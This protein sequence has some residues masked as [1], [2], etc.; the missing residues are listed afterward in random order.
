[1][2]KKESKFKKFK[3][4]TKI[5]L[6]TNWLVLIAVA[7]LAPIYA[8][9]VD[10]VWWDL[11]DASIAWWIFALSAWITSLISWKIT[12]NLKKKT[13]V[14]VFWYFLMWIWFFLYTIVDSVLFLFFVQALI[15]FGEAIYSPSFDALYWN[16]LNKKQ[17]WLEWG[18]WESMNYFTIAIWAFIWWL[19]V[20]Y[21][22]FNSIFIFMWLLCFGSW[23][24][25]YILSNHK[26]CKIKQK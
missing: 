6:L 3:K 23:T 9:F 21:L 17:R 10:K 12:D 22:W 5:L 7:M 25:L 14:V 2:A 1:M 15:G 11:M 18:A 24:Y 20:T 19:M 4:A 16:N 8:I 13:N 26:K